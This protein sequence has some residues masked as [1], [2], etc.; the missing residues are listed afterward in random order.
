M[1]DNKT[2]HAMR[3]FPYYP[4]LGKLHR[5]K[6]R[7][8][9]IKDNIIVSIATDRVSAFDV[10]L[11]DPIPCK[12]QVLTQ[13]AKHFF[14]ATKDI[15]PNHLLDNP[16]PQVII[17]RYCTPFEIEFVV[18]GYLAGSAWKDYS[19]GRRA[20]SGIPLQHGM[21]KNQRFEKPIIT[22]T[23]KA[24]KGHDEDITRQ[25][26]L[27]QRLLTEKQ[28]SE[29]EGIVQRLYKRGTEMAHE[30]NLI[31]VDT[32]YELG[33]DGLQRVTLI[34]EVHTP[35]SSRY[36]QEDS[37]EQNFR[38]GKDQRELSKEFLSNWLRNQG[39]TGDGQTPKLPNEIVLETAHR[40]IELYER[41]TG[42][43]LEIN[44]TP[45]HERIV[46]NLRKNDCLKGGYVQII[47]G[48]KTDSEHCN[49]ISKHLENIPYGIEFISAHK[50]TRQ[51]LAFLE[52]MSTSAEPIVYIAVAGRS[53]ALGGIIASEE[54]NPQGFTVI[55]CPHFKD[56]AS[57]HADI[58]SSLRMPGKI[59]ALTVLE[60]ENAA[61]AARNILKQ[62]GAR[63]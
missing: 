42:R 5:G 46:T 37:Y 10:I 28:L 55:N 32:K 44:Q 1:A 45:T 33:L 40:Y 6:V 18:R 4:E 48:S 63:F 24:K 53:N 43:Q 54:N 3:D 61:I 27:E 21:Q 12:G 2:W 7:D 38:E 36:W 52:N 16:D 13:I 50:N 34:D 11:D 17:C 26:I 25:E 19:T 23:T 14:E 39:F 58:H 35:D 20:K 62:A 29:I 47:A 15:V 56:T 31:L 51:L 41:M 8:N 49:A 59:P 9:Y 57:Y 22:N 60:P 30:R